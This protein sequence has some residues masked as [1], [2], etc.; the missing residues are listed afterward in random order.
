MMNVKSIKAENIKEGNKGSLAI[1]T[2]EIKRKEG[3]LY[4][5]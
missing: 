2:F 1:N 5:R 4:V 3:C